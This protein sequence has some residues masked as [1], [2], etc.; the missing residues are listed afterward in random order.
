VSAAGFFVTG[1]DTGVGKTVVACALVRALRA[2]GVDVGAMKPIETGV[3]AAGPLDA[4]ALRRAAGNLDPLEDVCPIQF[5]LPAAPNVA[6]AHAG[7]VVDLER[8][9]EAFSRIS[10]RR[11]AVIVEGAGGLLVPTKTGATMADLADALKLPLI[12]VARASLGTINHTLLTLEAAR[13]RG[14]DV[15]GVVISFPDG[16]LSAADA[17][18]LGALRA[19]LGALLLGEVPPLSDA[20]A[21]NG[22]DLNL[23]PLLARLR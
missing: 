18:N 20:A 2:A 4:I 5:E 23:A 13:A 15:A 21:A 19:Q 6:A 12:V 1:T 11:A 3:G 10:A 22:V 7:S 17:A 14:L 8:V 16:P 9:E